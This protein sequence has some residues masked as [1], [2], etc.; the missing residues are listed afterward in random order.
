[1]P[2]SPPPLLLPLHVVGNGRKAPRKEEDIVV[3]RILDRL[4][5]NNYIEAALSLVA[6]DIHSVKQDR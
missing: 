1:M 5:N 3:G 2:L 4:W 6:R